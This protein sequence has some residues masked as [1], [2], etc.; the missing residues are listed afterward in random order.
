MARSAKVDK[1]IENINEIASLT[2]EYILETADISPTKDKIKSYFN[3]S[4]TLWL[5]YESKPLGYSFNKTDIN[6][7]ITNIFSDPSKVTTLQKRLFINSPNLPKDAILDEINL[8]LKIPLDAKV[9]SFITLTK[10]L[11]TKKNIIISKDK[12]KDPLKPWYKPDGKGNFKVY[13]NGISLGKIS[14]LDDD[15][16]VVANSKEEL[17][18]LAANDGDE[19]YVIKNDP[20]SGIIAIKYVYSNGNWISLS[21]EGGLKSASVCNSKN[22]GALRYFDDKDCMAYCLF[23]DNKYQWKCANKKEPKAPVIRSVK[24]EE[25]IYKLTGTAEP[26]AKVNFYEGNTLLGSVTSDENGEFTFKLK[27]EFKPNSSHTIIAKTIKNYLTSKSSLPVTIKIG[28]KVGQTGS[29]P[30]KDNLIGTN[31]ID[32]LIAKDED[33]TITPKAGNDYIDGGNG[34]DTLIL[35]GSK[36]SYKISKQSD[37]SYLI[38][39]Q[40]E[41]KIVRGVELIKFSDGSLEL[42]KAPVI[43]KVEK[44][45]EKVA[46]FDGND[47]FVIKNNPLGNLTKATISFEFI[48]YSDDLVTFLS[49]HEPAPWYWRNQR[50]YGFYYTS[51]NKSLN[52]GTT[53]EANSFHFYNVGN[54]NRDIAHNIKYKIE[55]NVKY[56]VSMVFDGDERKFYLYINGKLIGSVYDPAWTKLAKAKF[57]NGYTDDPIIGGFLYTNN[58]SKSKISNIQLYN[59]ALSPQ[60]VEIVSNGSIADKNSL[61][62]HYD[63]EGSNPFADKSGHGHDGVNHGATIVDGEDDYYKLTGTTEANAKVDIYVD[64]SFYTTTLADKNGHFEVKFKDLSPKTYKVKAKSIVDGLESR[65]SNEKMVKILPNNSNDQN[66]LPGLIAEYKFDGDAKDSSGNHR[67]GV[68]KGGVSFVY[69]SQRK[70]KV[71]YFPGNNNSFIEATSY[72]FASSNKSFTVSVWVKPYRA[73]RWARVFSKSNTNHQLGI[74]FENYGSTGRVWAHIANGNNTSSYSE[75][76]DYGKGFGVWQHITMVR[77][78]KNKRL[79]LYIN[80]KLTT[81]HSYASKYMNS[82]GLLSNVKNQPIQIG[83]RQAGWDYFKGYMDDF[84]IYNRALSNS[85]IVKNMNN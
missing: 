15:I 20:Q 31:G 69:D 67:D 9:S 5:N 23:K 78:A 12:P 80:G 83:T 74:V 72:D 70:S 73:T 44:I 62:A 25:A 36:S 42:I 2:N 84:R 39:K 54:T 33:D 37:G 64:N 71:A 1:T 29:A 26:N 4:D 24:E 49:N 28:D 81:S 45:K 8:S 79:K 21:G 66:H 38:T 13:L 85:E 14:S 35:D 7:K 53:I 50:G 17:N 19:G 3:T 77:D 52:D 40:S 6:I 34:Y 32:I 63:F 22:I 55:N 68:K 56:K 48:K 43:T 18:K 41:T 47:W 16:A 60:E 46:K 10:A 59:K 58:Y 57:Y 61:I 65:F 11:S 51:T 30:K 75:A 82:S 27:N 76:I